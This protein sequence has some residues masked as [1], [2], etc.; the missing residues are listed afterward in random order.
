MLERYFNPGMYY[1]Y[2]VVGLGF[3]P[4]S[5]I[6]TTKYLADNY[7]W[8][9]LN[10]NKVRERVSAKQAIKTTGIEE[11][12]WAGKDENVISLAIKASRQALTEKLTPEQSP[13][14]LEQ[15]RLVIVNSSSAKALPGIGPEIAQKLGILNAEVYDVRQACSGIPY[16]LNMALPMLDSPKYM[17]N[18]EALIISTDTLERVTDLD[19][20]DTASLFAAAAGALL[21]RKTK[22]R[23]FAYM[24]LESFGELASLLEI[25]PGETNI[26][27]DGLAVYEAVSKEV[28]SVAQRFFDNTKLSMKDIDFVAFHQASGKVVKKLKDELHVPDKKTLNILHDM[29]NSSAAS[30]IGVLKKAHEEH[31][32]GKTLF[33]CFG[34]GMHIAVG[35]IEFP[36][37]RK[38]FASLLKLTERLVDVLKKPIHMMGS[39][40]YQ[41]RVV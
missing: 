26:H 16:M 20:Y 30:T 4:G 36:Q 8:Y 33:I 12:R 29:G 3:Q 28:L 15:V 23:R 6:I 25:Q 22:T 14:T 34:A 37:E 32:L 35:A 1:G 24:Q 31:M 9:R 41:S 17:E 13:S 40:I 19:N 38:R 39:P 18:D 10:S 5:E 7:Q 27:M 2:E 21:L 11:R